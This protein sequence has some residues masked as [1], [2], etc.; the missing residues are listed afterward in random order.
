[1]NIIID[2]YNLTIMVTDNEES[3]NK[4]ITLTSESESN[5]FCANENNL[6]NIT[7]L[8]GKYIIT[9]N[10]DDLYKEKSITIN[11]DKDN[12]IKL[13]LERKNAIEE[14]KTIKEEDNLIKEEDNLIKEDTKLDN[15]INEEYTDNII[16]EN[17]LSINNII[18]IIILLIIISTGVIFVRKKK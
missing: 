1:M 6:I 10:E 14:N 5:V 8:K 3:L 7:L 16:F 4:C 12:L 15:N 18:Y 11:L 2:N 17:T 9:Y 13:N